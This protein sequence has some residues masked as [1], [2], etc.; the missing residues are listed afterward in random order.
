MMQPMAMTPGE[1]TD[2]LSA[3]SARICPYYGNSYHLGENDRVV[4]SIKKTI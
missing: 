2:N 4:L 3:R 1:N